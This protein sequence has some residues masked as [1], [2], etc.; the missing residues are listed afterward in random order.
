MSS[1][2][3]LITVAKVA[4]PLPGR[5]IITLKEEASLATHAGSIQSKFAATPSNITHDLEIINGYAGEF[6]DDDLDELRAHPEIYSIEQDGISRT[7]YETQTDA[8]WGLGRIS[9]T[10][11]LTGSDT[12]L[13]FTYK[14]ESTAGLGATVY[15]IDTGIYVDHPAFEGRAT[16]GKT[17]GG[18]PD[19][20]GNGHGTHCAGTV[21]SRPF[22]VAKSSNVVAVKVLSDEG[23]GNNSD[24]IAGINWV[25]QEA[26][27]TGTPTVTSMSLGG[28]ASI[29]VDR[30]VQALIRRGVTV[31]VAAGND[32]EDARGS[33]P[34]RVREAI[35]VAASTFS[36]AKA[37]F[38][39]FGA[40]VDIFAPGR[41]ITSTW[42]DGGT[43]TISG[44]SMATPH[45]AGY[46][47]YLLGIDSSLTPTQIAEYIK[48]KALN[49]VLSGVPKGT[50][51]KL[52]YNGL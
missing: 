5:Y 26:A 9:S 12:D 45:V 3:P 47:A 38:S 31:V 30:A 2:T 34:A 51:N 29:S 28:G 52:L 50:V 17:F 15:V 25:A 18:Y 33:S 6:T 41:N 24:V 23:S 8:P 27:R 37:T 13:N 14:Y 19:R 42:M 10:E 39:N 40:L 16:W 48:D 21:A 1:E 20:D 11:K 32:D 4:K 35:T 7:C 49:G 22:G 36:D 44:T 46:A 43:K